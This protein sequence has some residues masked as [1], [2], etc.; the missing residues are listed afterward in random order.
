MIDNLDIR[1]FDQ[2]NQNRGVSGTYLWTR[3]PPLA[4]PKKWTS[5]PPSL[6]SGSIRDI[7]EFH[8][9]NKTICVLRRN[10]PLS[11]RNYG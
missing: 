9:V 1:D 2:A 11:R 5:C 8:L 3:C 6:F 10:I 7:H 4:V